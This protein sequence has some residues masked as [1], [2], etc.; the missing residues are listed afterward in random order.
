[1][2]NRASLQGRFIV[3]I[4]SLLW[5]PASEGDTLLKAA[6]LLKSVSQASCVISLLTKALGQNGQES[7]YILHLLNAMFIY[8]IFLD[9]KFAPGPATQLVGYGYQLNA[10]GF[11]ETSIPISLLLFTE[12]EIIVSFSRLVQLRDVLGANPTHNGRL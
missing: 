11:S 4:T 12:K 2:A 3:E 1:M 8:R 6:L 9:A 5:Q 10:A 7:A